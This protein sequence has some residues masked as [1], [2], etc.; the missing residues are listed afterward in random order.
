MSGVHLLRRSID[1]SRGDR[2]LKGV[3]GAGIMAGADGDA[4]HRVAAADSVLDDGVDATPRSTT[5]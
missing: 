5:S 1:T 2:E 3:P 4:S